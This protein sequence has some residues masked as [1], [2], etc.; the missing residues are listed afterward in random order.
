M[1]N[2]GF[3]IETISQIKK[4]NSQEQKYKEQSYCKGKRLT[5]PIL[6]TAFYCF[7][8]ELKVKGSYKTRSRLYVWPHTHEGRNKE[9]IN[10]HRIPYTRVTLLK[11]KKFASKQTLLTI[12]TIWFYKLK[13]ILKDITKWTSIESHTLFYS[14]L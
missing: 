14:N 13:T 9:P 10:S 7:D 2:C 1:V 3:K 5:Y 12:V 11:Y 4:G 6:I 8:F